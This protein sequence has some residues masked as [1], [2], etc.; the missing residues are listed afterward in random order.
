M[1]GSVGGLK[2]VATGVTGKGGEVASGL[3]GLGSDAVGKVGDMVGGADGLRQS[4][5]STAGEVVGF[6]GNVASGI[7]G[8]LG[9]LQDAVGVVAVL[10]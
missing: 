1:L 10:P 2:D 6:G 4:S 3:M 5:I 7:S 8:A 9:G